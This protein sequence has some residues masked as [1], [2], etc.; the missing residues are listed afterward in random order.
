[1]MNKLRSQRDPIVRLKNDAQLFFISPYEVDSRLEVLA[2]HLSLQSLGMRVH[3]ID[4]DYEWGDCSGNPSIRH[5]LGDGAAELSLYVGDMGRATDLIVQQ[6]LHS[7]VSALVDVWGREY[8]KHGALDYQAS[9]A[10]EILLESLLPMSTLHETSKFSVIYIDLDDFKNVNDQFNHSEG[11]KALRRVSSEMHKLCRKVGGLALIAGGDEF[12]LILPSDQAMDVSTHLWE[13]KNRVASFSFGAKGFRVGMTAGVVTRTV[14]EIRND[15]GSIRDLCE[16]LTKDVSGEKKKRRGTI[17]F[18]R[19][20]LAVEEQYGNMVDLEYFLKL[21][22]CLSKSRNTLDNAFAD[23]R[24]NLIVKEVT[25]LL[26]DPPSFAKIGEAVD[27]VLN[28]FGASLTAELDERSLLTRSGPAYEISFGA[29]TLAIM[30]AVSQAVAKQKWTNAQRDSLQLSWKNEPAGCLLSF[31]NHPVW[32]EIEGSA[33][34]SL[35]FGEFICN[36][37]HN[38]TEGIGVGV[39]I[40]FDLIPRTPGGRK[41]PEE[42]LIDHVRVDIRPRTGGGLPDFW[43]AALAHIISALDKSS[44]CSNII[45]WGADVKSTEIFKRLSDSKSWTNDEIA[46]LTGLTAGRVSELSRGIQE[47]VVVVNDEKELLDTLCSSYQ[48]FS[49]NEIARITSSRGDEPP[50]QRPMVNATPLGQ[51]EGIV[52]ATARVAY[53]LIV[54][55]LRKTADVRLAVDDSGQEQRELIAF[56]LK[57]TDPS[58]HKIP[59]YLLNQKEDLDNYA[60]SVLLSEKGVIRKALESESQVSSYCKYLAKYIHQVQVPKS[61]RRACLV[62]PHVPDEKGEPKPLG[63]ISVWSTPRFSSGAVFLDFVFVW[64]TVEAFIGLPY[65]LYGSIEL[66]E[67]LTRSVAEAASVSSDTVILGELNYVALSL[68]IGSDEFHTRVAKQIVDMASD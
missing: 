68:H 9:D 7:L 31:N 16:E 35:S 56:K 66:A 11:D 62:V 4:V 53:P 27:Q 19:V 1:M 50:L 46:S 20:D 17:N 55:T 59:D 42:F 21:G 67:Q 47:S 5:R 60:T 29:V 26:E 33:D 12:V 51:G 48:A 25:G 57:L 14:E 43:Q 15:F 13:F 63:L 49:G 18:E 58:Q 3:L 6:Q 54:D 34:G 44:T 22:L 38:Q 30:H 52:C 36:G 2:K 8:R 28:W 24:L 23:E 37:A 10:D 40:G 65:S 32:G 39:Q 45:V 64:R 41:L 61:T